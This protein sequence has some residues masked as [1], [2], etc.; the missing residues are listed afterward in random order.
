MPIPTPQDDPNVKIPPA[1]KAAA[2][3]ADK[4]HKEVYKKEEEAPKADAVEETAKKEEAAAPANPPVEEAAKPETPP[5]EV[6]PPSNEPPAENWEHKY[7]SMKG[8]F[9]RAQDTINGLTSRLSQLEGEV[10]RLKAAPPAVKHE[11]ET[12][13]E[14]LITPEEEKDYGEDFLN[15]VGKKAKQVLTQ[16]LAKRDQEISELKQKL[17]NVNGTLV[18]D[19]Q[20][21]MHTDLESRCPNW[22]TIN[23]DQNFINWLQLP[24]TYSGVIRHELLKAAYERNDAPRVLAFFNGFLAEEAAVAPAEGGEQTPAAPAPGKVPLDQLAAPGRAKSPA[25]SQAPVEKPTINRAQIAQF[26]ADVAA[27]K[28]RGRDAEKERLERMIFEAQAGG[29]IR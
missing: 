25:A 22:R 11:P 26:Y 6:T 2:A 14:P 15:V 18:Q 13:P 28:Y 7:N 17:S 10:T 1:V 12:P 23:T 16:E 3:R 21:R 20:S 9:D 4:V 5:K 29:R 24:D 8:R 19:A 27:G